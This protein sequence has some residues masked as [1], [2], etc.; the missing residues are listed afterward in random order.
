VATETFPAKSYSSSS[1][2]VYQQDSWR[3]PA[4]LVAVAGL[5]S[6]YD[7]EEGWV[8]LSDGEEVASWSRDEDAVVDC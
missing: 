2:S 1:L 4:A 6:L 5:L 7:A 8:N 3:Q